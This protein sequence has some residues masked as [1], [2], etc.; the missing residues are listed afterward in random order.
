V[1]G[2]VGFGLWAAISYWAVWALGHK[3]APYLF[4]RHLGP[5]RQRV[6][7]AAKLLGGGGG[8]EGLLASLPV[9]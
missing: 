5:G 7:V 9:P 3:S 8:V 6:W 1:K 4:R 2:I